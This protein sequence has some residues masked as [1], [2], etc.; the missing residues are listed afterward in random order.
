MIGFSFVFVLVVL[1]FLS[2][3]QMAIAIPVVL[4]LV[5]LFLLFASRVFL[6]Q[7]YLASY[8]WAVLL[9]NATVV[10]VRGLMMVSLSLVGA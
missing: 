1:Q 8:F 7:S 10:L 2:Y 3:L 5:A 9:Y 4:V 6:F